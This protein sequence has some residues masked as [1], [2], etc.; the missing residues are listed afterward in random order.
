ML[1]RVRFAVDHPDMITRGALGMDRVPGGD[2]AL[3]CS[4]PVQLKGEL[5]PPGVLVVRA[6]AQVLLDSAERPAGRGPMVQR[7]EPLSRLPQPGVQQEDPAEK[8]WTDHQEGHRN[9]DGRQGDQDKAESNHASGVL[10]QQCPPGI[11]T[12]ELTGD[13]RRSRARIYSWKRGQG[14]TAAVTIF[15]EVTLVVGVTP[16]T[17][18]DRGLQN[19]QGATTGGHCGEGSSYT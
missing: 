9:E 14:A 18:D 3:L 7:A 4:A 5:D 8:E 19:R 17:P 13:H 10:D 16:A 15:E 2:K 1:S 12:G 11:A 6:L